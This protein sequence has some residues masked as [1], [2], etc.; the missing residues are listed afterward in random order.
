MIREN[1][2]DNMAVNLVDRPA[3]LNILIE[4]KDTDLIKIVTGIRRCGKSTLLDLFHKHLVKNGI[5]EKQIVHMNLESLQYRNIVDHLQF[6]DF[7]SSKINKT[8]KTYLIFD[9]LQGIKNFEKAIESFRIDFDVDIYITGSNAYFLSAE[10]ATLLSGRYVEIKMLPLSFKE[11]LTFHNFDSITDE[12]KFAKY[13]QFGGLPILKQYNFNEK[14]SI[15]VLEG[16]YSTVIVKDILQRNKSV[17]QVFLEKIV[18]FLCSNIGSATSNNNIGNVLSQEGYGKQGTTGH[19]VAKYIEMLKKA[20]VFYSA[21]RYDV[22][23]K[24]LLKTLEKH[25][26]VDLGFRNLLLGYRNAERG[27]I[28]ENVVFLELLRRD[29]AVYVGKV[30][31]TEVDFVAEKPS[32]RVYIQVTESMNSE[33]VRKREIRPLKSISDNYEKI[34]LS[35]DR[36]F[37]NSY[38]GIKSLNL[39]DWLLSD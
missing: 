11:F 4:N 36:N 29:Y 30:G 14:R 7:V 35:L 27:H 34:I 9:E 10:F 23:G 39:I 12:Q 5:S 38:D 37:I 6:Y 20:F 8:K 26:V 1:L 16:I 18:R 3:Y 33:K 31:N 2:G 17:N 28:L 24:Q 32:E 13:L 22:K 15:Q 21:M 19:R 25:Y